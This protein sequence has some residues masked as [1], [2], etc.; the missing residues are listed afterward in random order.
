[1]S[2]RTPGSS[3]SRLTIS[4]ARAPGRRPSRRWLDSSRLNASKTPRPKIT[5]CP[6]RPRVG[7]ANTGGAVRRER[8]QEG[9][10]GARQ[11]QWHVD[12]RHEH[13]VDA[14]AIPSGIQPGNHRG[15]LTLVCVRIEYQPH[16]GPQVLHFRLAGRHVGAAHHED[17]NHPAFEERGRQD[18]GRSSRR[19]GATGSSAFGCPIRL[20][21]PAAR[22]TPG[23]PRRVIL[24]SG[25]D[26]GP[27][28]AS[29]RDEDTVFGVSPLTDLL[30]LTSTVELPTLAAFSSSTSTCAGSTR[31]ALR[32]TR[33]ISFFFFFK[34]KKKKKKKK[35]IFC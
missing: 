5:G 33:P 4:H 20:D 32:S 30:F 29:K 26:A 28:I 1:M 2:C 31:R 11:D 7:G 25:E 17:V 13:S 15:K 18:G 9:A 24:N 21:R 12:R 22:I 6:C 34:K 14:R 16:S 35:K 8:R 19:R 3:T 10:H 27:E 23:I